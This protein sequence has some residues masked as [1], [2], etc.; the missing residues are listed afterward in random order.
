MSDPIVLVAGTLAGQDTG[1]RQLPTEKDLMG[2]QAFDAAPHLFA[3]EHSLHH[4]N[5]RLRPPFPQGAGPNMPG[6]GR[7]SEEDVAKRPGHP[8]GE[9]S[10][11]QLG[12]RSFVTTNVN[13]EVDLFQQERETEAD[14]PE[15]L[16]APYTIVAPVFFM[17]RMLGPGSLDGLRHAGN[18]SLTLPP[19]EELQLI[20]VAD[21]AGFVRCLVE[22]PS[23]FRGK[24]I[25][26]V[27]RSA[28]GEDTATALSHF[29]GAA[30]EHEPDPSDERQA[31]RDR[32]NRLFEWFDQVTRGTSAP[33][34]VRDHREV[35]W[36]EFL[37][38]SR[39]QRWRWSFLDSGS[40]VDAA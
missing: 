30:F 31:H 13:P 9:K 1:L 29:V 18:L 2:I 37:D 27:S 17:E 24:R 25:D 40:S 5:S 11:W 38:W 28:M 35:E 19:T 32:L 36:L 8:C 7:T 12:H 39:E 16:D 3:S 14:L 6:R 10:G 21:L 33:V 22:R 20:G 23:L 4:A 26:I 34:L 15:R